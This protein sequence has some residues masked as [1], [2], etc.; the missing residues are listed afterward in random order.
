MFYEGDL[1]SGITKAVQESKLVACFVTD[2]GDESRSWEHDFLQDSDLKA[3]LVEQTILLRLQASS[4][5]AGY[6]AAIFPL[7]KTPTLVIIQNG[8]LKEYL[9]A[10]VSKEDF[11]SRLRKVLQP[12]EEPVQELVNNAAEASPVVAQPARQAAV[13]TSTPIQENDQQGSQEHPGE[14]RTREVQELLAERSARLEAH[15]KEQD[16][17][18]KADKAAKAKA[19]REAMEDAAPAAGSKQN[20]DMK[21]AL[22]QK[23]RQQEARDERARILKRV[24]DDKAERRE[25]E[26]L[27]K[28][29]AKAS[30]AA[31]IEDERGSKAA[32]SS[33]KPSAKE[34]ALQVRLFDGSTIRSKFPCQGTLRA[35]VRPWIDEQEGVDVPYT[36]KHVLTPL[37]NKNI[38]ISDEEENLQALELTPSATLILVPISG[39]TSA[40]ENPNTGLVSRG[41]SAGYGLVSSGVGMFTGALGGLLGSGSSPANQDTQGTPTTMASTGAT[42]INVQTLRDQETR[43]EDHQLYNGNALNFEPRKDDEDKK[44]D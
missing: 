37:P 39:Y 6:L 18:E 28:A 34:C 22:M 11:F 1:Q 36:F 26:A 5:E 33:I 10:G 13:E 25:R 21:Y 29:Q 2:D 9:A 35:D 15:K 7:P 19:R 27:R 14:D 16:A 17:R 31:S 4:T 20:A 44:E 40:Y 8:Q 12:V 3:A 42:N 24:E 38:S 41:L 43:P 23:K 30:Q 32:S